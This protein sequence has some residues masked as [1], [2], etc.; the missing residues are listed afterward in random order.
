M[1][2]YIILWLWI[3]GVAV[4]GIL[5]VLL[6][7]GEIG[8]RWL[9]NLMR[10]Y[11]KWNWTDAAP[12]LPIDPYKPASEIFDEKESSIPLPQK[13]VKNAL[14]QWAIAWAVGILIAIILF[15]VLSR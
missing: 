2:N 10:R 6:I 15:T 14:L 9:R 13:R 11:Q 12:V 7:Y 8:P 1:P 5:L 4:V 3:I